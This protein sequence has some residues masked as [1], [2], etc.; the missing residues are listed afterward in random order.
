MSG[1]S[2]YQAYDRLA[3]EELYVPMEDIDLLV[4][5]TFG[6]GIDVGELIQVIRRRR[7]NMPVLHIGN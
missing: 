6:T 7:P 5:D 3:A 1:Y 4:L 2:V